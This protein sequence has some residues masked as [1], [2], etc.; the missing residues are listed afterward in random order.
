MVIY[1]AR[2][3][4]DV[5]KKVS[6]AG[7]VHVIEKEEDVRLMRTSERNV[8]FSLYCFR[9]EMLHRLDCCCSSKLLVFSINITTRDTNLFLSTYAPTHED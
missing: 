3:G 7:Y 1:K 8:Y 4:S 6:I 5:L 2:E 9:G